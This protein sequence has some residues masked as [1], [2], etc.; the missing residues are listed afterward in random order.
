LLRAAG[1]FAADPFAADRRESQSTIFRMRPDGLSAVFRA[2]SPVIGFVIGDRV[3]QLGPGARIL[4][5]WVHDGFDL[6]NHTWSHPEMNRLPEEEIVR[7]IMRAEPAGDEASPQRLRQEY[8]AYS[9]A[10]FDHYGR[11]NTQVFG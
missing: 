9:S 4:R 7:E 3:Q 8:I 1:F 10:E 5:Q 6:G 11:L 2:W